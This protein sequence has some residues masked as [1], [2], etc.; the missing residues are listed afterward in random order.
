MKE[1]LSGRDIR[2]LHMLSGGQT[3]QAIGK[4]LLLSVSG[5]RVAFD[6]IKLKLGATNIPHAVA[7]YERTLSYERGLTDGISIMA[8]RGYKMGETPPWPGSET[9]KKEDYEAE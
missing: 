9:A 7:L 8:E 6:K 1:S 2:I 5:V 4:E 3:Y